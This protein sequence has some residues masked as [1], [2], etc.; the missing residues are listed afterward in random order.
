M[1]CCLTSPRRRSAWTKL[2]VRLPPTLSARPPR[3]LQLRCDTLD[4]V[5]VNIG[6]QDQ[7]EQLV[8][9]RSAAL[10]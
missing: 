6:A 9:M 4:L 7:W 2:L 3:T 10:Y 5:S 8:N 1:F